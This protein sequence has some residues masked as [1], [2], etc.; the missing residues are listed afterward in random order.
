MTKNESSSVE[1]TI[2]VAVPV[3]VAYNQWTQFEDFPK[4]MEGVESVEQ[5]DDRRLRWRAE[6]AGKKLEWLAEI[7]EQ[8]ADQR[9]AW[10]SVSGAQNAGVVTFHHISEG[11]CRVAL[12]LD[13]DPQGIVEN[14]GAFFGVVSRRANA[15]L[16]RFKAFIEARGQETGAWRGEIAR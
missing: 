5:L 2:D 8:S 4:F 6:I 7:T 15:D 1:A 10:R 14:I 16:E 11:N 9:I 13:Y 3:S 12:Q